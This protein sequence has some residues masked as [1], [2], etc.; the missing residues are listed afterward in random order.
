MFEKIHS[1]WLNGN[2]DGVVAN[3]LV[4]DEHVWVELAN[5]SEARIYYVPETSELMI[6][7]IDSLGHPVEEMFIPA[8]ALILSMELWRLQK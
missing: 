1:E 6:Q 5:G 4:E 2:F 3:L 7:E 8:N